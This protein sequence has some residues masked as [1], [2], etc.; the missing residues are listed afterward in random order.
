MHKGSHR[1][2]LLL[3]PRR[4]QHLLAGAD[5]VP[6]HLLTKGHSLLI[7]GRYLTVHNVQLIS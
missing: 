5:L 6:G 1:V 7:E 4:V 3:F 2:Q